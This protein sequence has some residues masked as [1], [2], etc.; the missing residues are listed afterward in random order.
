M[1]GQGTYRLDDPLDVSGADFLRA[2]EALTGAPI[3]YG[4]ELDLLINGDEIFPAMLETI[5]AAQHTLCLL[6]YVYWSGEIA[7]EVA[8]AIADRARAGVDVCVLLDA[9]GSLRMPR[10]V[11]EIM[12]GSGARVQ[13]FRPVA[14]RALR[15][16][17]N[18][19]HRKLLIADGHVGMTGG[20]GIAQEWTGDAQDP[21]HWRDTHVRVRGPVVRG[22][23]GA[24]AESWLEATGQMLCGPDHLP[25]LDGLDGGGPMQ[26]V[27]SRASVGDTNAE[28]LLYLAIA[29]ARSTIDLT[30]A[31]FAPREEF[32]EALCEAARRGV[33]V[34]VLVPGEHADKQIVRR[35]GQDTYAPLLDCGIA[36]HEYAPTML[37]AKTLVIDG[38]WTTIGSINFDNRSF[39]RNDEA[40]LCVQSREVAALLSEQFERDL[41]RSDRVHPGEWRRRGPLA[42]AAEIATRVVRREL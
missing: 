4:N 32:S 20:V 5:G 18:R 36:I 8:G 2:C 29:S 33:R 41:E 3:S 25:Q 9:V 11:M 22:L 14:S 16:A 19:N 13:R 26:L 35:A 30:S 42:R 21:E 10:D 24:F 39:S 23:H 7:R 27:R 15:R 17:N 31:Y 1:S 34:R 37:H 12:S 6:S 28:A 40:T 38:A